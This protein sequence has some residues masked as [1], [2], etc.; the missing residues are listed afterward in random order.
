VGRHLSG[1][2]H[3]H[4][5]HTRPSQRQSGNSP[6]V[7][8]F[9]RLLTG[10]GVANYRLAAQGSLRG[11]FLLVEKVDKWIQDYEIWFNRRHFLVQPISDILEI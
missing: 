9:R 10:G 5:Y 6:K 2:R 3:I 1:A 4:V 11:Q 8:E 7:K